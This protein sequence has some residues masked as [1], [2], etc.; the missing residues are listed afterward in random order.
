MKKTL[1]TAAGGLFLCLAGV[2]T[3]KAQD[4]PKKTTGTAPREAAPHPSTPFKNM[5]THG[6]AQEARNAQ[7]DRFGEMTK[8]SNEKAAERKAA[9]EQS[10]T[11]KAKQE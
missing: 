3:S 4:A 2:T 10:E 11:G 8:K 5:D 9:R 7:L 6:K 1:L